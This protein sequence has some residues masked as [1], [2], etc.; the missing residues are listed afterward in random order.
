MYDIPTL[1]ELAGF[2]IIGNFDRISSLRVGMFALKAM[3]VRRKSD[4]VNR[5]SR[6]RTSIHQQIGLYNYTD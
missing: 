3:Q 1:K 2:N 6:D 4:I 5:S